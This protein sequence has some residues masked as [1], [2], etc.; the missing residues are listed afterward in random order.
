MTKRQVEIFSAGCS[1]CEDT[2]ALVNQLACESCEITV[3]DMHTDEGLQ[4]ARA[5]GVQ[6]VPAVAVNDELLACCTTN[7]VS[8]TA[9]RDSGIGQPLT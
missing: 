3:L 2:V 4:R 9:L 8:D 7:A 6:R 1:L 5:L